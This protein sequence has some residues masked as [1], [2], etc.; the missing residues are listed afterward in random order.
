MA[1]TTI[2]QSFPHRQVNIYSQVECLDTCA[3]LFYFSEPLTFGNNC[4]IEL[5]RDSGLP[6]LLSGNRHVMAAALR[7]LAAQLVGDYGSKV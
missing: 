3:R 5:R 1:D 6:I 2:T 4:R 7:R